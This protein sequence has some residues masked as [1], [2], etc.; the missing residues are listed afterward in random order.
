MATSLSAFLD[1]AV[2]RL[3]PI[4]GHRGDTIWEVSPGIFEIANSVVFPIYDSPNGGLYASHIFYLVGRRRGEPI[5]T[6]DKVVAIE[7]QGWDCMDFPALEAKLLAA[8]EQALVRI[9]ASAARH[10][11]PNKQNL[12]RGDIFVRL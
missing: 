12:G 11:D 9:E 1:E 6:R 8:C 10:I 2:R 5:E 4:G 7:V 3:L